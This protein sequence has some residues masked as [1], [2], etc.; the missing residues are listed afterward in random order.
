MLDR[1]PGRYELAIFALMAIACAAIVS[2]VPKHDYAMM[3]IAMPLFLVSAIMGL[4]R[5]E[6]L[7]LREAEVVEPEDELLP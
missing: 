1:I 6:Q 2:L 4:R 5:S 3:F 7:K